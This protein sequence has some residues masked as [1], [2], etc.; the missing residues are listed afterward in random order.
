MKSSAI[1]TLKRLF[2]HRL[3]LVV[4]VIVVL[5]LA[6]S[7]GREFVR[8]ASIRKEIE[9]LEAQKAQLEEQ[10]ASLE[11]YED[12]LSTESF[13]EKEA[14]E[15]FGLQRPGETQVFVG[16]GVDGFDVAE[17]SAEQESASNW[18]YWLWYFFDPETY[19]KRTDA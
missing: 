7:F 18:Q 10:N 8:S 1:Q 15:K 5:L 12:Y 2:S 14:R 9:T 4:N 16:E 13:L 3:F 11:L 6:M 17:A 19:D